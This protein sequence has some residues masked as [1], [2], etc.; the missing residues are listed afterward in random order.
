MDACQCDLWTP[1]E[2]SSLQ[3]QSLPAAFQN[4]DILLAVRR[5]GC[6]TSRSLTSTSAPLTYTHP[7]FVANHH[8][9]CWGGF[10]R[11]HTCIAKTSG[12]HMTWPRVTYLK[13]KANRES[14]KEEKEAADLRIIKSGSQ[15][16]CSYTVLSSF[17]CISMQKY[18]WKFIQSQVESEWKL[19]FIVPCTLNLTLR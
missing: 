3:P 13:V 15:E 11:K 6:L 10:S 2:V 16:I 18:K 7:G 1:F 19:I 5:G 8:V 4:R 9:F 14:D 12:S 17:F